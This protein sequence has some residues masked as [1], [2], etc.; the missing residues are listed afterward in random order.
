LSNYFT[1]AYVTPNQNEKFWSNSV[2][3]QYITT[4]PPH[5]NRFTA[6]FPGPPA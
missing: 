3:S 1:Y 5:H 4:A 6:L 2:F